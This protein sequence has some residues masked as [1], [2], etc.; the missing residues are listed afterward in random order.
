MRNVLPETAGEVLLRVEY[1]Q[2]IGFALQNLSRFY[3]NNWR[4]VSSLK[5]TEGLGIKIQK[6]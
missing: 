3:W 5:G 4:I 1:Y 6:N 2:F